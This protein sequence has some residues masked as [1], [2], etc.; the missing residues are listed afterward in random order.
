M[1]LESVAVHK[2]L[3]AHVAFAEQPCLHLKVQKH[4]CLENGDSPNYWC[5]SFYRVDYFYHIV[6]KC[7]CENSNKEVKDVPHLKVTRQSWSILWVVIIA[8]GLAIGYS[9]HLP[10]SWF[11]SGMFFYFFFILILSSSYN[12]Y[13]DKQLVDWPVSHE[14]LILGWTNY[15]SRRPMPPPSWANQCITHRQENR[16]RRLA[17]HEKLVPK[18]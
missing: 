9:R 16:E 4:N 15:S 17:K 8:A 18:K 2:I 5:N 14:W 11:C 3:Y 6:Q 13:Q 12:D 7:F 1:F 10:R